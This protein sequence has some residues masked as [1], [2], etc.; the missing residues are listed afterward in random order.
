MQRR[1]LDRVREAGRDVVGRVGAAD[2]ERGVERAPLGGVVAL[3]LHH[4]QDLLH[5]GVVLVVL[6]HVVARA[7]EPTGGLLTHLA[8]EQAV[9]LGEREREGVVVDDRHLH[10]LA[11]PVRPARQ[12]GGDFLVEVHVLERVAHVVGGHGS[13]VRPLQPFPD[14]E[15]ELGGIVA[16]FPALQDRGLDGGAQVVVAMVGCRRCDLQQLDGVQVAQVDIVVDAVLGPG[17]RAA[18]GAVLLPCL[19]HQRI[20]RQPLRHRRQ[21]AAG[22]VGRVRERDAGAG[23]AHVVIQIVLPRRQLRRQPQRRQQHPRHNDQR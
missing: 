5:V 20:L 18:V 19:H 3:F 1:R 21:P 23:L 11:A 7:H 8:E 14:A 10:R 15:R 9:G 6:L 17:Q 12:G 16:V 22:Q 2:R 13:A 4:R